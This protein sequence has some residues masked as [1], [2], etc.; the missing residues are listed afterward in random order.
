MHLYHR[1]LALLLALLFAVQG[2]AVAAATTPLPSAVEGVQLAV[3]DVPP[4]HGSREAAAAAGTQA[5]SCCDGVCPD[6]LGCVLSV[7]APLSLNTLALSRPAAFWASP[8]RVAAPEA[9]GHAALRP[10]I[11][12]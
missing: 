12:L 11:R 7:L 10:P 2:P 4:C 1:P 3:A 5:M 9:P 8:R 6:M